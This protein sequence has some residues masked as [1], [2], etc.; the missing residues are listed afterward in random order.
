LR[1]RET[2]RFGRHENGALVA[3]VEDPSGALQRLRARLD[4]ELRNRQ[5]DFDARALVPHVTLV[6]PRRGSGPLP[7]TPI[8]LRT[9]PSLL[10]SEV[11]LVRSDLLPTG[12]RYRPIATV[13][14]G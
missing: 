9:T 10:V 8:D 12:P 13:P 3:A 11:N 7:Q 5:I 14:L 4:G 6:R 1:L 2:V